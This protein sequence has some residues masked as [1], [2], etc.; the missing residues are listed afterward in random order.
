MTVQCI[1][2]VHFSLRTAGPMAKQGYGHCELEHRSGRFESA[3]FPRTCASFSPVA[4]DVSDCRR[5]WLDEQQ[6][7]FQKMILGGRA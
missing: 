2:C 6:G 3:T 1:G 5:Q 7:Q 4:A